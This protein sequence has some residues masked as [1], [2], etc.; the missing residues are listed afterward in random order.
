MDLM[1]RGELIPASNRRDA[2]FMQVT[3]YGVR[4]LYTEASLR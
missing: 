1:V 2:T 3:R 4:P